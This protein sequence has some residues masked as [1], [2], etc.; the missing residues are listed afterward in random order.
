MET[1]YPK[2]KMIGSQPVTKPKRLVQAYRQA[3]WRIATQQGVLFLI[4]AILGASILWVMVSVTIQAASA[5]LEIQRLENDRENLSRKIAGLRTE[6]AN[7]TSAA[8]ME[9]RAADMGF[10][11]IDPAEIIYMVLPGYRGREPVI[12]APPP[13]MTEKQPIIKPIYTQ[14][15]WEW[16]LQ[17]I[18]EGDQP[19]ENGWQVEGPVP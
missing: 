19:A 8:R 4:V 12:H 13:G 6:I 14:S 1:T 17:G 16:M 10:V 5:G 7:Q 9:Q 18:L 11:P 3:P 2:S 15:L